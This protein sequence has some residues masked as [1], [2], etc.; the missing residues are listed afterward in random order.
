MS[1]EITSGELKGKEVIGPQGALLGKVTEVNLDPN[2]WQVTSFQLALDGKVAEQIGLKKRFGKND[3]PLKSSY[4]GEVGDKMLVKAS[5]DELI[6]YVT[7]LR[8][9]ET[10]KQIKI[11]P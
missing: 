7:D 1:K 11:S 4:V 6:Q 3:M 2:S 9:D 5:R 8:V 10:T